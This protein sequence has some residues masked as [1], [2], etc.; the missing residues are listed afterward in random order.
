RRGNRPL[1]RSSRGRFLYLAVFFLL[2]ESL[3]L[4]ASALKMVIKHC[5]KKLCELEKRELSGEMKFFPACTLVLRILC[6]RR[7]DGLYKRDPKFFFYSIFL[8]RFDEFAFNAWKRKL[9]AQ[10]RKQMLVARL[11][12]KLKN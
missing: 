10:F 5:P 2:C 6:S 11:L 4:C 1:E 3:C 12:S 9:G 7:F 8:N